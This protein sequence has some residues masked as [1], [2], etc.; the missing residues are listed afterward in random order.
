MEHPLLSS[1]GE[2]ILEAEFKPALEI[3]KKKQKVMNGKE[4]R[5]H[6]RRD[7]TRWSQTQ[8]GARSKWRPNQEYRDLY[9]PSDSEN[10]Y[11]GDEKHKYESLKPGT[12][13]KF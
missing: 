11:I 3:W 10:D 8:G 9:L 12:K 13:N 4:E 6:N 1:A 5:Y 2:L 7:N